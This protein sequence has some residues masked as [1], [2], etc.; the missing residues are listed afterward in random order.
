MI[1]EHQEELAALYAL[2]LL[3]GTEKEQFSATLERD[4]AL[5]ALVAELRETSSRLAHT[6]TDVAPPPALRA[7]LL[8]EISSRAPEAKTAQVIP[9]PS[10]LSWAVA[11]CFAVATVWMAQLYRAA[12]VREKVMQDSATLADSS[13]KL[14]ENQLEAERIVTRQRL[15]NFERQIADAN[16]SLAAAQQQS[17]AAT[18]ALNDAKAQ[19]ADLNNRLKTQGDLAQL[20]ISTLTSMLGNSAQAVAV[21]VWD[22][23]QQEGI[24]SVEKMPAPGP[25]QD[26]EL[27]V[28]GPKPAK[29]VSAGVIAV[30]ADGVGR[31]RFKPESPVVGPAQFAI[32]R[33]RKGGAPP[34]GGPQGQVVMSTSQ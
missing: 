26:Y 16:T 31:L 18:R 32:S 9:F 12:R 15:A 14:T 28:I 1:D 21:A 34:H 33:E 19:V 23:A 30:S 5:R 27:W 2:D 6:A 7:R 17:T 10:W 29:P 25:D 24:F 13:R 20:K 8:A 3:E 22:P 11:A 4:P